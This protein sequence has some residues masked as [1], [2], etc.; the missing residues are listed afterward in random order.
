MFLESASAGDFSEIQIVKNRMERVAEDFVKKMVSEDILDKLKLRASYGVVGNDA[1]PGGVRFL[2][3]SS[4]YTSG[5]GAYF[6]DVTTPKIV[7]G[8]QEGKM[9][10]MTVTWET[11]AKK[12]FGVE[13]SMF[14]NKLSFR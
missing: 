14:K 3:N 12:N 6:G 13:V 9:G 8:Y 2:Y 5:G 1:S 7:T 10:N 4:E 11:A